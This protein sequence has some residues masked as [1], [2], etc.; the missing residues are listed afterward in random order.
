MLIACLYTHVKG[1]IPL[2]MNIKAVYTHPMFTACPNMPC[3]V[4]YT[5]RNDYWSVVHPCNIHRVPL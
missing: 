3:G 5:P 2:A 1:Y 4:V